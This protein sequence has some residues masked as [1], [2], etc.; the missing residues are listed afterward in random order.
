MSGVEMAHWL[1]TTDAELNFVGARSSTLGPRSSQNT[2]LVYCT[3]RSGT[4]CGGSCTVYDGGAACIDAPGTECMAASIDVGFCDKES[5]DGD[6]SSLSECGTELDGG[7]CYTP[8]TKSI[9][10]SPL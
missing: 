5:C 4:T 9:V 8:G 7:Y 2:I 1:A 10:V 6:C 3:E